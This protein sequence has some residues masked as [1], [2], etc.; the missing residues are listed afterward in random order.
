MFI[1]VNYINNLQ[2]IFLLILKCLNVGK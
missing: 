2:K 1:I